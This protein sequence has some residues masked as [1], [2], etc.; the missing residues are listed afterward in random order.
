[1]PADLAAAYNNALARS[2]AI[3]IDLR[4]YRS[5]QSTMDLAAE[6]VQ[7]GVAEG[8]VICADEQTAGRGRR[9]RTWS[10]PAGAG[11]Y[12][13]MVWRP[14]HDP[15]GDSRLLALVTLAAG[16]GVRNAIVAAT[17]LAPQL[18]WPNDV[19]MARCKLAGILA[20]GT[21]LGTPEQAIVV[22][23]G[24]NVRQSAYPPE[25]ASRATSLE[26]EL[27]R[28]VDR[29][30]L[31]EE[32]LIALP[33]CYDRLRSG[34]ADDILRAWRD[35]APA[36]HGARVVLSERRIEGVTAGVDESGA[37]LVD[38]GKTIERVIAGEVI[39]L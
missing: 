34:D 33:A 26:T 4:W 6:A 22:G 1:L 8:L 35:A 17:G 30:V 21:A 12:L 7:A 14:P 9:G 31:L 3:R 11:L 29:A 28:R 39:W 5:V 37:L 2:P 27:G 23:V 16:V 19:V 24:I 32:L 13:S 25:I 18:K 15:V 20:E 10:S 36:A 38:T